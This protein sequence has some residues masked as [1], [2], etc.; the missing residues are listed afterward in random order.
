[1]RPVLSYALNITQTMNWMVRQ[2]SEIESNIVSV[3]RLKEYV[4]L[5]QEA[6]EIWPTTARH[7]TG[8][9]R[10]A[11]TLSTTRHATDRG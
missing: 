11:W 9:R 2:Y 4:E 5:P 1:M 3:E 10:G 7:S 8:L 6:P